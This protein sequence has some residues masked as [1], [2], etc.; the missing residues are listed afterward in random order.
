MFAGGA[1]GLKQY[2]LEFATH[3]QKTYG[4]KKKN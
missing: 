2:R 4:D 1:V 3:K